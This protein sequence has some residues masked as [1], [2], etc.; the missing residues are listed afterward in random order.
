[1][2]N[3]RK[4]VLSILIVLMMLV[5][6]PYEPVRAD[7]GDPDIYGLWVGGVEVT[8]ENKE[9]ILK[10]GGKAKYDPES[11]T[12]TLADP[13]FD[14]GL[15]R[16]IYAE[17]LD[18]IISGN[19]KAEGSAYGIQVKNG[20]LTISSGTISAKGETAI[21]SRDLQIDGGKITAVNVP[22]T[23][24][25]SSASKRCIEN[26]ADGVVEVAVTSF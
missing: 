26:S 1:M 12:L 15:E 3:M 24:S 2:K 11:R 23:E 14:S 17:D 18:L 19:V 21:S 8:S 22:G 20:K 5:L 9:D 13:V 16:A 25:K 6:S 7:D 4:M 10:D